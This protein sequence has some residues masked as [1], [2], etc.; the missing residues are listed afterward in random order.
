VDRF[1]AAREETIRYHEEFYASTPLG[2]AG[3]WLARPHPSVIDAINLVDA[4]GPVQAFDL[5]AGVGRH[6]LPMAQLLPTGSTVTA[7]DMLPTAIEL[8][9]ANCRM[10]KVLPSVMPVVADLEHY[11]F[12]DASASLIVGFSAVEHVSSLSAMGALLERCRDA[13]CVGGIVSFGIVA[14]RA[15]VANDGAVTVGLVESE[16]T[17]GQARECLRAVFAGWEVIRDETRPTRVVEQRD[18]TEYELRGSLVVF[19]ARKK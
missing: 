5:G 1:S 19:T 7:V 9:V 8:L 12:G 13:M 4:P 6:T 18:G 15:E 10:G 14:D 11:D 2:S 16:L 17:A 3:S